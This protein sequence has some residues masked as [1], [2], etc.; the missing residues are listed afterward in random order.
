MKKVLITD[1]AWQSLDPEREILGKAGATLIVAE[2]GS[3]EELKQLAP[4]A[5]CIL[6][7]WKKVTEP[8]IRNAER[9][10]AIGRYGIGLDN[11]AVAC[12]T[13]LGIVVTNVPAYCLEEVAD[14][15]MA[16]LLSSARKIT[17]FDRAIKS[18]V[19][20]LQAETP[21][22]RL[23]GRTLGIFGFGKIGRT[24]AGKALAFGLRVIAHDPLFQKSAEF[25]QVEAVSFEGLLRGSDYISIHVPS[26]PETR[27]AFNRD[28]FRL[29]KPSA[30]LIN[31]ARGDVVDEEALLW[32]LDSNEIAG[33]ALDVLTQ[34]P[35]DPGYALIRHPKVVATP[36]AAFNS[37]ESL[38]DLQRTAACQMASVLSGEVPQN[39]VN[40][41]VLKQSNL[42]AVFRK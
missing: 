20:N 12:A 37:Q 28:A 25:A 2:T 38:L 4:A 31:T 36:H 10:L 5:D 7:C 14:H 19:Y 29:M 21:L 15:A 3:E 34:E 9:C 6:T 11:I 40:P 27:H 33:A 23:R 35:P 1:Y 42:R 26:T 24:L 30:V 32:A 39:V 18:G 8:V 22:Y 13:T 16:M 41:E 17:A